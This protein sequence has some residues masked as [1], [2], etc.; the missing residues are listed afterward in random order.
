MQHKL[1][2]IENSRPTI[3]LRVFCYNHKNPNDSFTEVD[4]HLQ[5]HLKIFQILTLPY[6]GRGQNMTPSRKSALDEKL[7]GFK[8]IITFSQTFPKKV[9]KKISRRLGSR[10]YKSN[11]IFSPKV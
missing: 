2:D 1:Q 6:M 10:P 7:L 8:K 11:T 5:W 9:L 3:Y 4:F